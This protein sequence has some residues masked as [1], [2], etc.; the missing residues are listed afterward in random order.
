MLIVVSWATGP[1]VL[2]IQVIQSGVTAYCHCKDVTSGPLYVNAMLRQ[3]T[4][5][6]SCEFEL[7]SS[8][9]KDDG[10]TPT[11]PDPGAA[12]QLIALSEVHVA[13]R[14]LLLPRLADRV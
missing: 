13:T 6:S 11:V 5:Q 8:P 7:V 3:P 9:K 12:R 2:P 1:F 4:P 10:I 14:H